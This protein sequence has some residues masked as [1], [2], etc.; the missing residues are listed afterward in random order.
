VKVATLRETRN[1]A[2]WP[3]SK[4][5]NSHEAMKDGLRYLAKR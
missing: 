1:M 2:I 5:E 3:D 4:T